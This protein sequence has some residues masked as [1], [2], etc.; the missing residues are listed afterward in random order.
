MLDVSNVSL[1]N[2]IVHNIGNKHL[3]ER[4]TLSKGILRLE[5]DIIKELLLKYFLSPFKRPVYYNFS[6]ESNLELNDVFASVKDI[7]TAPGSF[8]I[9]SLNV[10]KHLYEKS[11]HPQIK[12][13]EFYMVH[14]E[15]CLVDNEEVE[16]IGIFKSENKDTYLK[17]Y[18]KD[19]YF[20]LNHDRG[21]N[22]NK[23]DKGCLIFN[24]E[25]KEGYKVCIIDTVS[26]GEEAQYWRDDFLN[27]KSREDNYHQ[28]QNY[29]E[30]CRGFVDETLIDTP[31]P[32]QIDLL[33]KSLAFFKNKQHFKEDEFAQEV[34]VE[35]ERIKAFQEYKLDYQVENHIEPTK[36]FEISPNALRGAKRYLRSVLK[37]DKNFHVYIHGQREYIERGYD[38]E[39]NLNYYK[40]F[41]SEES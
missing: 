12:R 11:D 41:Y 15:N 4:L 37:L 18:H 14:F 38:E 40:L 23:L 29:I 21:I 27:L 7:F 1:K 35:P 10:A 17:V 26:R 13:G 34:I 6:H 22:I 8:Y 5:E 9:Q 39:R 28:T 2:I 33:N 16:A 36:E 24:T 31:K 30:M 3:E 20:E 32:D 25:E 19:E